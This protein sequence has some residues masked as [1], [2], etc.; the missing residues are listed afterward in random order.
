MKLGPWDKAR[1]WAPDGQDAPPE[2]SVTKL[3]RSGAW[4]RRRKRERAALAALVGLDPNQLAP[5]NPGPKPDTARVA[6]L[7]RYLAWLG[8]PVRKSFSYPKSQSIVL[9]HYLAIHPALGCVESDQ[10]G[11]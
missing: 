11:S 2:H 4:H 8:E 1:C 10:S 6:A 5:A 3:M 9:G 7:R